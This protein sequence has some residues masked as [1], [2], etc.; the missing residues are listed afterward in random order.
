MVATLRSSLLTSIINKTNSMTSIVSYGGG[1]DSTAMLIGLKHKGVNVDYILFADTGGEHQET[2]DYIQYFNKWLVKN[3]MPEIITVRYKTKDGIALTLEQ[4]VINNNTLPAIAFGWKTCSQKFKI[5]PVE[6]WL[7]ENIDFGEDKPIKYI[8]FEAGEERRVKQDPN[9]VYENKY[10]LI[11]WGWSRK[12]AK[13]V[14]ESEGLCLPPKSSCFFCPNMKKGEVLA[15]PDHLKERVIKIEANATKVA[16]LKGLGRQYSWTDL[17]KAD[18]SQIKM[19]D[20]LDF[21]QQPCECLD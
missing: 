16:E 21:Y 6:K 9:G 19:F 17:I 8:G 11:E 13:Q 14:I 15:L 12:T 10:P 7:K 4:D 2:Y 18:E 5:A 3:G 1:V 20:D